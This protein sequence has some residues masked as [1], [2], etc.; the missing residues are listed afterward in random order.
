MKV[1]IIMP[2]YNEENRIGKTLDSYCSY[3]NKLLKKERSFNCDIL[4]VINGT[5]DNTEGVVKEYK[6]KFNNLNYLNLKR[7]GKG[8]AITEGFKYSLDKDYEVIGFVD[9]DLATPPEEYLKL[10]KNIKNYDGV[11]ADRYIKGSEITPR[12]SFRRVIVSRIFNLIVRLLFWLDYHDTQCGA[13]L[14]KRSTIEKIIKELTIT[15]WAY[16]IDLLYSCKLH[17][18]KIKSIPTKWREMEASTLN[19]GKASI[20]MLFAVMQLRV[21][22]SRF[23]ISLKVI[24]PLVRTIYKCIK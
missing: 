3:F 14:F 12:F 13:K 11:I 24:N 20:Q 6:N 16:D 22:K 23:K 5:T 15:Q 17:R 4:V 7:G 21:L 19:L 2:A 10:I 18:F 9:A 1:S 8:F